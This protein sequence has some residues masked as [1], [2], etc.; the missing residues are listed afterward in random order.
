MNS[1]RSGFGAGFTIP[2][3]VIFLFALIFAAA[4]CE[5]QD[6]GITESSA[7]VQGEMSFSAGSQ[8]SVPAAKPTWAAVSARGSCTLAINSRGE[9]Y[10][11]GLNDKGQLGDGTT[12]QGLSP[13]KIAH[14]LR[15]RYEGLGR[16]GPVGG[17]VSIPVFHPAIF[18]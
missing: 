11:W 18:A 1:F 10:A 14:P 8:S 7:P 12:A 3:V 13:V 15:A 2:A 4:G 16:R 5:V 6:S 17:Q 9:L